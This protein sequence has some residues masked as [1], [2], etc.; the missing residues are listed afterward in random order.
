MQKVYKGKD[1]KFSETRNIPEEVADI[2][3][4][5]FGINP[6]TITDKTRNFQKTDADG[7]TKAK[8]FLLKNAKD[9]FARLPETKDDFGKGTFIPKNVCLLYTSDAAD[10]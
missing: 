6:Q 3:G 4:E 7:L 1:L 9:D 2:Y 8:Q 5:E 10:E